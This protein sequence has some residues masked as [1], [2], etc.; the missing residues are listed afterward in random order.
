[1]KE[2]F[3]LSGRVAVVTGGS[4][5]LGKTMALALGRAGAAVA[6][7]ARRPQWLEPA[8]DEF[9]AA[10]LDVL[11]LLCDVTDPAAVRTFVDAVVERWGR[12]DVLVNN[13]GITWG[14]TTESY[15]LDKWRA[16]LETNVTGTFLMSQTVG[17]VMLR[18]RRGSIINVASVAGMGGHAEYEL[19]AIGYSTSKGALIAFTRDL[20]VKWAP[21]GIRVNAIAPGFFPTRMSQG[22]IEAA[23]DAITRHIPMGR[24]G[25]EGDLEGVVVFLASDASR[26]VTGQVIAVDGGASAR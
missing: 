21:E 23:G 1:V 24:L 13:A 7:C 3:D 20:A 2:L 17:R 6:V 10:G 25:G 22:I 19:P 14:A 12:I 15:P 11:A 18:A 8:R 26:Y 4:R 9:G 5:G 16:V